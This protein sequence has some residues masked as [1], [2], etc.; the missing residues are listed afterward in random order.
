M[1]DKTNKTVIGAGTGIPSKP[2][3]MKLFATWEVDRTPSNCI[4]R[5]CSLTLSRLVVLR[6]LGADLASISIAVK[7]QSSKRTLRSN[8]L[9]LPPNGLLDTGLELTFSL[10]YPHFLKRDGNKLHI[11][12]QRRKRYKNRTMLGFKTLAEGIIR[13]DQVLQKQMDIELELFPENSGKDKAATVVARLTV[14]QL[15]STPVDQEHKTDRDRDFSDEE[16]EFSSAEEEGGDLSDSEPLRSK[17]PHARHNLKQRFVSLLRRFRMADSEGGRGASLAN[18]SDIQALFQELESL[19]CDEDSGAEQDTMSI[20]STPKP[21]L[22]PFFS[23]S[24]SLLDNHPA[25]ETER[26]GEEKNYSGSDGNAD[27]CWTDHEV[28]SDPQIGSPPFDKLP[29]KGD[30]NLE[31]G[32]RK[33]KLF[34]TPALAGKKKNSLSIGTECTTPET[35]IARKSFLEQVARLLPPDEINLPDVVLLVSGTEPQASPLCN[36]L[37]HHRLFQP[38]SG[39]EV[40]SVLTSLV[41]KIQKY[42]NSCAKPSN[43]IKLVL[44]GGDALVGWTLR[45]YVDLL[46][47]RSP[48]WISYIRIYIVPLG[49]CTIARHLASLDAG[50]SNLFPLDTELKG[51]ELANRLIRYISLPP[52]TPVANLPLA[53]AMLTCQDDSSQLFIP[54]VNEV[55]VGPTDSALSV[56]VDMEDLMCS[57]PPGPPPLT[58]PSSPNVQARESPWE[59]LE[60]QLDYWQFPKVNENIKTDKLK[61]DGKISLKGLFRGLQANPS[62]C[63]GLCTGL[64][65]TMHVSTKEKKQKIMRLGKKKEKEREPEARSQFVEGISRLIC[66]ARASH[67]PPMRVFIDGAEWSGVKFFQ[68]SSTWQTHIK[69]LTVALVGAPIAGTELS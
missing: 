5:L 22:R 25:P 28:Q 68:L 60:L 50:Y 67:S 27:I 57:S 4:P 35:I 7:M 13:M 61:Q 33:S 34:R 59:P 23:S 1:G 15:S 11:L 29:P 26:S 52:F 49:I 14:L 39:P 69:H 30:E 43:P 20:S 46:S 16:D 9:L 45:P 65:L 42:C 54:F 63:S 36:R 2:V 58:P 47:S 48:E 10:Q 40:R 62:S 6:P 64:N 51:D 56:S 44:V 18:P 19:S 8:E 12:L 3:P 38:L 17:M 24:R 53:E 37:V 41:N 66:S 21:S 55:R 31:V 32:E